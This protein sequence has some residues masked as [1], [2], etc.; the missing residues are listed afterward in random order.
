[1]SFLDILAPILEVGGS[2]AGKVIDGGTQRT[3]ALSNERVAAMNAQAI[4][5]QNATQAQMEASRQGSRQTMLV[6]GMVGVAFVI[7]MFFLMRK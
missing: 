3:L 7:V 5:T 2:V 1:M 4:L 6:F